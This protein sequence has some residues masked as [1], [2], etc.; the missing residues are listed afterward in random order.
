MRSSDMHS[1][2]QCCPF[3]NED[4][5]HIRP[6]PCVVSSVLVLSPF[7]LSL[8]L[9]MYLI[10]SPPVF[11]SNYAA[12]FYA[13]SL[14]L[15][16]PSLCASQCVHAHPPFWLTPAISSPYHL[17]PLQFYHPIGHTTGLHLGPVLLI[18][19]KQGR[20]R[21]YFGTEAL[22]WAWAWITTICWSA[23][24]DR[25]LVLFFTGSLGPHRCSQAQGAL[26]VMLATHMLHV[27]VKSLQPL[28]SIK[29]AHSSPPFQALFPSSYHPHACR[30]H[31]ITLDHQMGCTPAGGCRVSPGPFEVFDELAS[32]L[33]FSGTSKLCRQFLIGGFSG[34]SLV[35]LI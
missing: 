5:T 6:I 31:D 20:Q 4:N 9:S 1:S 33:C 25:S 30:H 17:C 22:A 18:A 3:C 28:G 14:I 16:G 21:L 34:S 2:A 32:D 8:L 23:P 19:G 11:T 27:I 24:C 7:T 15:R 12:P 26:G 13:H 29:A 35:S 10:A